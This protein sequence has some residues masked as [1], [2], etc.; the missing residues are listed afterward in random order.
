MAFIFVVLGYIIFEASQTLN[1]TVNFVYAKNGRITSFEEAR[2]IVVRDE[3]V[4]DTSSYSGEIQVIALDASKVAKNDKILS[5]VS[6]SNEEL[7]AQKE[8]IEKQIQD[9]VENTQIEPSPE[10]KQTEKNIEKDLY[11]LI[12]IKNNIYD[13]N[14]SRKKIYEELEKKI[15]QV[16]KS[17][18]KES[19]L[20]ALIKERENFEKELNSKKSDLK[21]PYAGLVSYR[22]DGFENTF[23][24]SSFSNLSVKKIKKVKYLNNQ[25]V[26]LT[27]DKVKLIDNFYSYLVIITKSE[28]AK[29]LK[30]NDVV[31]ISLDNDFTNFEKANIEYIIDDND[32]RIIVLKISSKIEKLSQYR[33]ISCYLIWWNYE[34]IKIQSDAIYETRS[35]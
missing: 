12:Q 20:N 30:L 34:G 15:S 6:K 4:L 27:T 31:K 11:N 3:K 25:Q 13:V 19:E 16:G 9:V 29:K 8:A 14:I 5:F 2:A 10:I 22:V 26:P 32:E 33:A 24:I 18:S 23:P 7:T 1:K 21:A 35:K 28:D 17:V